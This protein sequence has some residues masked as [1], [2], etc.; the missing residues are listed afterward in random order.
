[1]FRTAL[2]MIAKK[3]KPCTCLL[4]SEWIHKSW[5]IDTKHVP[6]QW[7]DWVMLWYYNI[8]EHA[9]VGKSQKLYA[10]WRK[11]DTAKI[12][13]AY[14]HLYDILQNPKLWRQKPDQC[15]P[16]PRGGGGWQNGAEGNF[17]FWWNC[18]TPWVWQQ[19]H[20]CKYLL[21]LREIHASKSDF[22]LL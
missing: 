12:P 2:C 4:T 19:L 9:Q 14:F 5:F 17:M 13:S 18:S 16:N 6:Q 7:K 3:W 1:M 22:F 10:K 15:L 21:K 8:H 11:P 20:N